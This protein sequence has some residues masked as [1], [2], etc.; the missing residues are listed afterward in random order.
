M[1]TVI[2]VGMLGAYEQDPGD[3][4]VWGC[5]YCFKHQHN[6]TRNFYMD[7]LEK[8]RPD[9]RSLMTQAM[10]ELKIPFYTQE[11]VP[12]IPT[13]IEYPIE[14]VVKDLGS[15]YFT[16]TMC[17]MMAL[18]IHEKFEKIIVHRF[19]SMPHS[20]EYFHQKSAFDFWEGF[21]KGRGIKICLSDDSFIG[22]AHPWQTDKYGYFECD[23]SHFINLALAK[24]VHDALKSKFE[25]YETGDKSKYMKEICDKYSTTEYYKSGHYQEY[26]K[27][28]K[29]DAP[30]MQFIL[31]KE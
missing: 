29:D 12:E 24:V 19:H 8:A 16:S 27:T 5:S 11:E 26:L 23:K 30:K 6:L 20:S 3:A 13:S 2:F 14:A 10:N 21:A 31:P 28:L 15:D 18:A 4:E 1:K 22:R 9:K 25:F 7:N 17:Y